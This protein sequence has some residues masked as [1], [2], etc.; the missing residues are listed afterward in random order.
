[1]ASK[2][3]GV[4]SDW[5]RAPPPEG[6]VWRRFANAIYNPE[7]KSILGRT[8]KRWGIVFTFYLVFYAVLALLFGLCMGGLFL[9]IDPEKPTYL[10]S[11]SLIGSNPGV[12][13][14]PLNEA[15]L[16]LRYSTSN[17]TGIGSYIEQL[18][19]FF[20]PYRVNQW[21]VMKKECIASDNYGFPESP[22]FFIKVNK[23]YGW[24]PEPYEISELPKDMPEDLIEHISSL[25]NE[26]N[27]V[28]ISCHDENSNDTVFEYP[29]GRGLPAAFYPFT[30]NEGYRSPLVAVKF[31]PQMDTL[32]IIRC[33]AWAKNIVRNKSLKEPSGYTRIQLYIEENTNSNNTQTI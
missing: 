12:A 13:H 22:C 3:N 28:W 16:P 24:T 30:N 8:A 27:Q 23:I 25:R 19:D 21:Y 18:N 15:G 10:L 31:T 1:M 32:T 33:I 29:W 20:R 4:E 2:T 11:R 14:R 6:S 26:A 7:E 17:Y 5:V 9:S